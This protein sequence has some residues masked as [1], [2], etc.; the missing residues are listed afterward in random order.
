MAKVKEEIIYNYPAEKIIEATALALKQLPEFEMP[1]WAE[2]VK[3]GAGKERPPA[4]DD[5][6]YVRAASILRKI[7][8]KKIIGTERLRGEYSKKR[9]MGTKPERIFRGSGK[10][11]RTILQ[12]AERA[13]LVEKLIEGKRG[14]RLTEKGRE[15]LK[16]VALGLS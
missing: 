3:T 15:F 2:F 13:G 14:R 16:N 7:Y 9:N 12:Q 5:W 1:E 4:R 10:I 11:I 6:W 8:L